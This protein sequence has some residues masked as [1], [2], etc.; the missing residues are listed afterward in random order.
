VAFI[1]AVVPAWRAGDSV[2]EARLQSGTRVTTPGLL[3]LR[4]GLVVAQV[5]LAAVLLASSGLLL[6][7]VDRL[8]AVP[9]GF[10]AAGVVTM[11]VTITGTAITT[12]PEAQARYEQV[13]AAVREV[14][15]VV[16]AALTNQ[17]PLGGGNDGYG[18][19]RASVADGENP[20]V[21][22]GFRYTVT[23]SWFET[24][25]I[26]LKRG[27]LLGPEDLRDAP[28]AILINESLAARRFGDRDPIGERLRIGPPR[29]DPGTIVGVVA[30]VR[31][32]SLAA[33]SDAFYVAMGQWGWV[34][35]TQ[36]LVVRTAAD[37]ASFVDPIKQA[38]WSVDS[39]LPVMRITTMAELVDASE[40]RRTFALSAFAAFGF[41]A[42]LLAG[43]G[44]YGVMEGRVTERTREI[45]LR[46][47]LG[48]TPRRIAA[49]VLGQGLILAAIG[50]VI[51][52]AATVGATQGIASLLFGVEP[53]DPVTYLGVAALLLAVAFIASYAPAFRAARID[54]AI[55]LRAD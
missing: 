47:A 23:P 44:V 19:S 9:T 53:F 40:A 6:R 46:S 4:R 51:G 33:A 18:I 17:L 8:M 50:L 14:P 5:A 21:G 16:G 20:F 25:G 48:A 26:Q 41:A 2:A 39:T 55:T 52:L 3:L 12:N 29:E 38:I 37:P 32:T 42:L 30:D 49:F 43:M 31:H 45:G 36:S 34:D 22:T 35:F 54:P 24:M 1:V 15:G 13:L 10:D 28:M 7:S 11:Q 27:R